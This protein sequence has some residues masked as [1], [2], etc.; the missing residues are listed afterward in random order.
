M[1]F[2]WFVT[3]ISAVLASLVIAFTLV[4]A[5]GAPQEAAGYAMACALAIVPYVFT[6]AAVA[7]AAPDLRDSINRVVTAIE[8]IR[9]TRQKTTASATGAAPARNGQSGLD[10]APTVQRTDWN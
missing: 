8:G 3:L 5:K 4:V 6:R 2:F 1:R 9:D 7:L 10:Q